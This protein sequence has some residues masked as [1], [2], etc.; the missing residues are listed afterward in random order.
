MINS[1]PCLRQNS[2]KKYVILKLKRRVI[3]S[4]VVAKVNGHQS[5]TLERRC[6][7]QE[8]PLIWTVYLITL[9]QEWRLSPFED[10][11]L[12]KWVSVL[13]NEAPSTL[14]WRNLKTEVSLWKRI[15]CFPSTLC[16]RNLNAPFSNCFLP[17][18]KRKLFWLDER[19]RISVAGKLNRRKKS[20]M[21]SS[22]IVV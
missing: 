2:R 8:I 1:I 9:N 14:R 19:F 6:C 3:M 17:T 21:S 15:K 7:F 4:P 18:R 20:L 10:R 12:E 13:K 22:S 11:W 5:S 16:G